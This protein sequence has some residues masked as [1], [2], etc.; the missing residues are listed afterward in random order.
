MAS[1]DPLARR[2]FLASLVDDVHRRGATAILSS[3]IISDVEQACD[4]LVVLS[5]GRLALSIPIVQARETFA[6]VAASAASDSDVIGYF[7]SSTGN[8]VALVA[9]HGGPSARLEDVVLGHLAAGRRR[10]QQRAA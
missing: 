5:A 3:H 7:V 1:L 8:E 2:D 6:V 10:P 4:F 9:R